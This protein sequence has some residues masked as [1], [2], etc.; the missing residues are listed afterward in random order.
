MFS[1]TGISNEEI[2]KFLYKQLVVDK[3]K[4]ITM[5]IVF[6]KFKKKFRVKEIDKEL[7]AYLRKMASNIV[8]D[9][10]ICVNGERQQFN[11]TTFKRKRKEHKKDNLNEDVEK[12]KKKICISTDDSSSKEELP[13]NGFN[14]DDADEVAK[15]SPEDSHTC[16][17]NDESGNGK[18]G[19]DDENERSSYENEGSG[20]KHEECG[21]ENEGSGDEN[22]GDDDENNDDDSEF[23]MVLKTYKTKQKI[24]TKKRLSDIVMNDGSN[25]EE[26]K[27]QYCS[28]DEDKTLSTLKK[29]LK[30][31]EN[32]LETGRHN[33]ADISK[34][35]EVNNENGS[36][37]AQ[38]KKKGKKKNGDKH[39]SFKQTNKDSIE[40]VRNGYCLSKTSDGSE[41]SYEEDPTLDGDEKKKKH[42]SSNVVCIYH[43]VNL[44]STFK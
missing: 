38:E 36:S 40:T 1:R 37:P 4:S 28:S 35:I 5:R 22:E 39:L 29:K 21:D 14:E 17:G 6:D 30:N 31:Y 27:S 9:E 32:S 19:S 16:N 11:Q 3:D 43:I 23:E 15:S 13:R 2:N 26:E 12:K 18:K 42:K 44:V 41:S 34:D 33:N 24:T 10:N 8:E 25:S 20:D 7:K